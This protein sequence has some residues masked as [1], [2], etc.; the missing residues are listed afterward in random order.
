M[1]LSHYGLNKKPFD[2]SPN[3]E[4]LWL[5]EKHQEGLSVLKYGILENKGF[6]MITGEIGTGK[7]ALIRAIHREIKAKLIVVSIP[8]PGLALLDFYNIL[9]A[10]LDMGRSFENKGEFL[11]HFKRFILSAATDHRR[12]LLIID[13][14]QRLTSALLE[15]IRLLSNIDLDGKVV[16]NT[17]FVGQNEFK[18]LLHKP[19]NQAVRQR[20]TVSYELTPLTEAE[21]RQYV[22]HRLKVAGTTNAIF[23]VE[24]LK[25]IHGYSKGYPRLVNIICDHALM[26]GY[27]RGV[28]RI[29]KAIID[30]C[31][32][33]LKVA[34][35]SGIRKEPLPAAVPPKA[36][37]PATP[38]VVGTA[39]RRDGSWRTVAIFAGLVILAAGGWFWAG[40]RISD[41]LARWGGSKELASTAGSNVQAL[42][43]EPQMPASPKA[44]PGGAPPE[45]ST[46]ADASAGAEA[47]LAPS[48]KEMTA[49]PNQKGP[50][51]EAAGGA[52]AVKPAP[53]A[54]AVP[55]VP[56]PATAASPA[57][58][59][60]AAAPTAA[61][62]PPPAPQA[63]QGP[64]PATADAVRL[65][66]VVIFF[67]K[68]STEI[69]IYAQDT[70]AGIASLLKTFPEAWLSIEG[71]TDSAG[72]PGLNKIISEGRAASVK[73]YLEGEGIDPK[74]LKAVG[75]GPEK[76]LESNS[77][78]E[79]RT[80]NRRVVIRIMVAGAP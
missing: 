17:F 10:E 42:K 45:R 65:K 71:H 76:P 74:R 16:I 8:D 77:T 73:G 34:I 30:E 46:A 79:G 15:E 3:P 23:T 19:E 47:P 66:E 32:E 43:E 39:V 78:P 27:A 26:S 6:L 5:G 64:V 67:T 48:P 11:V 41:Q 68:N 29:D 21:V 7:T 60:A 80:K 24:A 4:F 1:Y 36:A 38:P 35:G 44:V 25:L 57:A 14:S 58:P 33:E 9:A 31:G 62:P 56:M 20:I 52:A 69:P 18:A 40:D 28:Q 75:Y 55:A 70:V 2:I 53:A 49:E 51:R 13:E 37:A 54:S 61:P 50:G 63:G 22:E 72:D 12:V 59:L